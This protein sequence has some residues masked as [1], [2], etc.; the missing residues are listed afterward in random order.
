MKINDILTCELQDPE[1]AKNYRVE[2]ERSASALAL[3]Y[4][5]EEAGLT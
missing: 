3:Y 4:A 1:F 5:R 2:K